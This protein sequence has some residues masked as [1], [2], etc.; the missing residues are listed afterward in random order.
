MSNLFR[1]VRKLEALLTDASGSGLA[2][3]SPEWLDYWESWIERLLN[4]E[5]QGKAGRIPLAVID[6]I[7]EAG[8]DERQ[9]QKS[10]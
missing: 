3:H 7:I 5:A 6:S 2:P 4:G 9:A 10:A 1:R 8:E